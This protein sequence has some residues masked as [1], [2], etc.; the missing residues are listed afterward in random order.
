MK[1]LFYVTFQSSTQAITVDRPRRGVSGVVIR[2]ANVMNLGVESRTF[3][4]VALA[5]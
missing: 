4:F 2:V 3:L 1:V 5:H